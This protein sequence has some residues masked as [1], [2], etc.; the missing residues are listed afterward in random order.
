MTTTLVITAILALAPISELRGAIPFAIARG[1]TPWTAYIYCVLL[2]SLVAPITFIFLSTIHKLMLKLTFYKNFAEKTLEK[3]R[4]KLAPKV[5]KYG[6]WGIMI[7]VAIPLP[8][9]GAYTGTLG[10]WVLGIPLKKTIPATTLGVTI[11][12]IIVTAVTLSGIEILQ[13]FIKK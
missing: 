10:A 5:E 3:A 2:N 1:I 11:S 12:G 13:I 9:T 7:F 8:I 4:K 6:M